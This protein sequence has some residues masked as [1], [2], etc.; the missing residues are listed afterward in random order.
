MFPLLMLDT[1][2]V[3]AVALVDSAWTGD[4]GEVVPV[5]VTGTSAN[6]RRD[7]TWSATGFDGGALTTVAAPPDL[8]KFA[9]AFIAISVRG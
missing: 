5:E 6:C 2:V 9:E 1:L 3:I 8:D 4:R 7:V